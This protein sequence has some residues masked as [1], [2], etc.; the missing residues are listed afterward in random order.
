MQL[1]LLFSTL[2]EMVMVGNN[3]HPSYSH[4]LYMNIF[5]CYDCV[6]TG[7]KRCA[8]FGMWGTSIISRTSKTC[9]PRELSFGGVISRPHTYK[10]LP[11]FKSTKIEVDRMIRAF[12]KIDPP[13]C[14]RT[15]LVD[16]SC[17]VCGCSV[18][19]VLEIITRADHQHP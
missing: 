11:L 10:T 5:T 8:V 6:H 9:A 17:I 7:A 16:G 1:A 2:G 18:L 19:L 12:H 4:S 14:L 13:G 15:L 3:P